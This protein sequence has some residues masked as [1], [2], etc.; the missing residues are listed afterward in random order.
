[1]T[2]TSYHSVPGL[3]VAFDAGV[4]NVTLD[5][6]DKRN[7]ISD[8]MI[9]AFVDAITAATTDDRVRAIVVSGAGEH[10]CGGA[11]IVARNRDREARPHIG[12]YD[13]RLRARP[14]SR[15]GSVVRR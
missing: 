3:V 10:F 9:V 6:P 2:D 1:M 12:S 14:A 13:D 11:D 7:A 4:L 15:D 5:R 8:E